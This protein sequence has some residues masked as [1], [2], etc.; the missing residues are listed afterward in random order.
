MHTDR[1]TYMYHHQKPSGAAF[2][3]FDF[4]LLYYSNS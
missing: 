1:P 3:L 4:I 2:L